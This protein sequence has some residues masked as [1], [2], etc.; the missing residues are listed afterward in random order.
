[1][2]ISLSFCLVCECNRLV[3]D[4]NSDCFRLSSADFLPV[5][6]ILAA[7]RLGWGVR[8]KARLAGTGT[9]PDVTARPRDVEKSSVHQSFKRS[10]DHF[11]PPDLDP[12]P[13][14][15]RSQWGREREPPVIIGD[16]AVS[17]LF[18]AI[19]REI[20]RPK[21]NF[22]LDHDLRRRSL[23]CVGFFIYLPRCRTQTRSSKRA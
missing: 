13:E 14:R 7:I 8:R 11:Q 17:L 3:L 16:P 23:V 5:F 2:C 9:S 4:R 15:S 1:M 22:A 18:S 6:G 10:D 12:I 20:V 19:A 21:T